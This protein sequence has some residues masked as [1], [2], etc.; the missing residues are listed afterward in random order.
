MPQQ[1]VNIQQTVVAQKPW[2]S[3]N[4]SANG[5]VVEVTGKTVSASAN[6]DKKA[7]DD[8][9]AP[10]KEEYHEESEEEYA[11]LDEEPPKKKPHK[12]RKKPV[13]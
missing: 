7:K 10:A 13:E 9:E 5:N 12:H 6:G 3:M 4:T 1:P 2:P 8:K 11:E